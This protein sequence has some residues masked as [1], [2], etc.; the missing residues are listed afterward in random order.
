MK[1]CGG[2]NRP[3]QPNTSPATL[4]QVSDRFFFV[5]AM[6]SQPPAQQPPSDGNNSNNSEKKGEEQAQQ[7]GTS[8]APGQG[9]ADDTDMQP[10]EPELPE[11]ILNASADE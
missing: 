10:A 4:I 1:E 9:S 3:R 2:D 7:P 8:T 6:S 11:D 5:S